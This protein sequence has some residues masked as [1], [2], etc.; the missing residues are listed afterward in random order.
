IDFI[1]SRSSAWFGRFSWGDEFVRQL[2]TFEEQHGKTITK[3]YQ[4]MLSNTRTFSPTMVNELR[5]GY[6]QFQND[7]L[8]RFGYERDVTKELGIVG[9]KSPVA[10]A[11]GTPSI[12]LGLGLTGFGEGSDGPYVERSHIFQMI[13]NVSV[14]RGNHSFRF[15][16]EF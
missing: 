10:A 9:L 11:W 5:L 1:E 3:T 2:R 6:T 4:A 15:G 14:V 8:L 16:G 13:D 12:G 7:Q